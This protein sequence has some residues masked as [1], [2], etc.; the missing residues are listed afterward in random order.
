MKI[1]AIV[2]L[3]KM[4]PS[5]SPTVNSL[6]QARTKSCAAGVDFS[7]LV[8][9]N[10]PGGQT[11]GEP[12]TGVRFYS[13]PEN[14]GLS[15]A[16]NEALKIASDEGYEWLLT[17]DQDSVL[18]DGF[19]NKLFAISDE[20]RGST[21]VAAIVPTVSGDGRHLSPFRFAG[22]ALPRPVGPGFVGL[23]NGAVYAVNSAATVR[24]SDVIAAGGYNP[25]FPLDI[26]D[27]DLFHRL[28]SAGKR[29]YIAGDLIVQHEFSLLKKHA[30]MSIQ[31]Y[32]S[33]LKDECAFWDLNV[34]PLG[35]LERLI[36]LAGRVVKDLPNPQASPFRRR[37]LF[38]I[39]RRLTVP[40]KKRIEEWLA[41]ANRRAA[42]DV[43]KILESQRATGARTTL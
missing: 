1:F 18:P 10:T 41:F 25:L 5:E 38:E 23:S 22:N 4:L 34:G 12:P 28:S 27:I 16:Y 32:D 15:K 26:S 14:L 29:L 3:Y 33:Q 11:L 37:T 42:K 31:R 39:W 9:D 24:I 35:R 2:V 36:R 7:L 13:A 30:R 43:S 20:L 17:L 40:R 21:N 19:L 8:W 6:L